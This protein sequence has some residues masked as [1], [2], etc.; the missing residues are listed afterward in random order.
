[1]VIATCDKDFAATCRE[2]FV[3]TGAILLD[4]MTVPEH[5]AQDVATRIPER[6]RGQDCL[7][8][9]VTAGPVTKSR[10]KALI[11]YVRDK[12][13]GINLVGL[14]FPVDI[15]CNPVWVKCLSGDWGDDVNEEGL[16]GTFYPQQPRLSDEE[17]EL[18]QFSLPKGSQW[19]PEFYHYDG[20]ITFLRRGIFDDEWHY[21]LVPKE[22]KMP[23]LYRL[24]FFQLH[25]G[26]VWEVSMP[27]S[28]I[29]RLFN[30]DVTI[31]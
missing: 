22:T 2:S 26:C 17:G 9:A 27:N 3:V 23:M 20:A 11:E 15:N 18:V 19:L 31:P 21:Y 29:G 7:I 24:P 25:H 12:G 16:T 8:I 28:R 30:N 10:V 4:S 13:R 6:Y 1:M 5:M 14:A